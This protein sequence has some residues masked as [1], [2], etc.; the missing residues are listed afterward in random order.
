MIVSVSPTKDLKTGKFST[1]KVVQFGKINPLANP[2]TNFVLASKANIQAFVSDIVR[3]ERTAI[4][5]SVSQGYK[6]LDVLIENDRTI[7][8][9]P[10][11]VFLAG[12][13]RIYYGDSNGAIR[14][15]DFEEVPESGQ[16]IL[17]FEIE[18]RLLVDYQIAL[19]DESTNDIGGLL[20]NPA[21]ISDAILLLDENLND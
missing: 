21:D 12:T 15:T 19:I 10:E 18:Q 6:P 8:T 11:G 20:N 3:G 16:I 17:N 13:A 7:V 1:G 5:G 9:I 4:T 2:Q 14:I